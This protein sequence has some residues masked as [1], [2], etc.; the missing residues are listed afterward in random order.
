M[1]IPLELRRIMVEGGGG[2]REGR[3]RIIKKKFNR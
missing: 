2:E 1:V 3:E